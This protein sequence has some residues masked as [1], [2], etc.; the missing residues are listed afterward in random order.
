MARPAI[1]L[2][3]LSRDGDALVVYELNHPFRDGTTHVLLE[4]LDFI[5]R[6]TALPAAVRA[7]LPL[8]VFAGQSPLQAAWDNQQIDQAP[9]V[10]ATGAAY[11]SLHFPARMPKA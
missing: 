8:V 10:T 6:L 9:L 11:H 2:E 5:A 4:P 3:R 1:T 7:S